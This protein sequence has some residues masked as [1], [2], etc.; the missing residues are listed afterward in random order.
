MKVLVFALAAGALSLSSAAMAQG[1]IRLV[2][3]Q[4][5]ASVSHRVLAE[6]TEDAA[7]NTAAI[8]RDTAYISAAGEAYWR[9]VHASPQGVN[10]DIV[11]GAGAY[12]E[13]YLQPKV[14][15]YEIY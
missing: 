5:H 13:N 4:A 8:E 10:Y 15:V 12:D 1:R 6:S 11:F 3:P 7:V 2:C 9:R 14:P